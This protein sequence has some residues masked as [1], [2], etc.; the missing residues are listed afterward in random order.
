MTGT[1]KEPICLSLSTGGQYF[2]NCDGYKKWKLNDSLTARLGDMKE[3]H[4]LWLGKDDSY[5]AIRKDGRILW[6]FKRSHC[7]WSQA[8]RDKAVGI[9]VSFDPIF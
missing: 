6:H 2:L 8:I 3:I 4:K 5:V 1:L 9:E 7:N